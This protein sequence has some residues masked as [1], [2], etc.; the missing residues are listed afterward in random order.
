[1]SATENFI[2]QVLRTRIDD[3]RHGT[4][5]AV[6]APNAQMVSVVGLFNDWNEESHRLQPRGSSGIWEGF[7]PEVGK[8]AL[9][10]LGVD[11]RALGQAMAQQLANLCQ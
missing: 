3:G 1:M 9:V 4:Y 5:F 6:W 11:F 10:D 7:L 8:G 2:E